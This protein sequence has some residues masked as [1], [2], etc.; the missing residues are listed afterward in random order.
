MKSKQE[1]VDAQLVLKLKEGEVQ[2]F[3]SLFKTYSSKLYVFALGYL[4]SKE[5]A[6]GLVQEVFIK[7]WDKRTSL[8][9][10]LSFKSFIFT[11]AYNIVKK[12]FRARAQF[13]HFAD[14]EVLDYVSVET[15]E[16]LDYNSTKNLI[17]DIVKLLPEKRRMVFVKSR[18]D[19]LTNE[20]IA[21]EFGISKKTVENHLNLA[22]KYIRG[23][24]SDSDLA[25]ML[26]FSLFIS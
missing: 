20:E 13:R 21:K 12:T 4:K 10:E 5:D 15:T 1:T 22:I 2:A 14:T 16:V 23:K 7:V 25:L 6:E 26:F 11:I 24:L 3:N 18:F 8:K 19:G 17:F 9:P